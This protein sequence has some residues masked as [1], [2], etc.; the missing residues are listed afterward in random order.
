MAI[1]PG[2]LYDALLANG[3]AFFTGV[4]DSLLAP[5]C[6]HISEHCPP[7]I[8]LVAAN[9]GAAVGIAAGY[10][11]GSGQ[12]PGVYL[13]N[14][15][16][17]NAVNPLASL[18]HARVYAIPLLLIVGWRG[19]PG[20]RDE[21]QHLV[22]GAI[23]LPQLDLLG[24]TH[25]VLGADSDV[26]AVV[27]DLVGQ[28]R[29]TSAPVALVVQADA[30]TPVVPSGRSEGLA[31]EAALS[32]ILD[33]LRDGDLV[34][35]TTGKTSRELFELRKLRGE[36]N[37]DFLTVGSMGHASAI[38]LGV[39]LATPARRVFCLDGDG[40]ALMHM[41][42]LPTI[43]AARPANLVHVVLANQAHES[44][45][46]QP[47]AAPELDFSRLGAA[48]GYASSIRTTGAAGFAEAWERL[49]GSDGP[50][51]WEVLIAVGSRADLGRPTQTPAENKRAFMR[52]AG[53]GEP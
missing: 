15:G 39:A 19:E 38:A 2:R 43:A 32:L 46:G 21:P 17:G 26:E 37:V 47:T 11:L 14:S 48:V 53:A 6:A 27:R 3:V 29:G 51:L 45:G 9:E 20:T 7:G 13:Q 44:V 36:V 34:V 18:T 12:I 42:N 10:H 24:I 41:G 1:P 16:L 33:G 40:A 5:L 49:D 30:F 50:V 31:R 4:P 25:A 28:A 52:H 22:Q 8:H 23:T 35:A